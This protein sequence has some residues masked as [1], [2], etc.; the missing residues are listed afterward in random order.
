MEIRYLFSS[1]ELLP[2]QKTSLFYF[3]FF[4]FLGLNSPSLSLSRLFA[5]GLFGNLLLG[6]STKYLRGFFNREPLSVWLGIT[7]VH[8]VGDKSLGCLVLYHL[9]EYGRFLP[10]EAMPVF[11]TNNPKHSVLDGGYGGI[12]QTLHYYRFSN[13]QCSLLGI[14]YTGELPQAG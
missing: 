1:S 13:Q 6:R 10:L 9:Q 11:R 14:H 7:I 4:I 5:F 3:L 8:C 2:N 12:L